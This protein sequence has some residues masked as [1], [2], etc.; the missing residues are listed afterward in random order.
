VP[1][2]WRP[3][4]HL[5][6]AVK[7]GRCSHSYADLSK[8][9]R[10]WVVAGLTRAGFTA[11]AIDGLLRCSLRTVRV[12]QADP[13]FQ[14]C[15][16]YMIETENSEAEIR[17]HQSEEARLRFEVAELSGEND[18]L[19]NRLTR[20]TEK[21]DNL[22]GKGLHAMTPY[23]TYLEPPSLR[24]RCRECHRITVAESRARRKATA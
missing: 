5:I 16:R 9:D 22:C 11:E 18:R 3:D 4:E 7:T 24:K 19:R 15:L 20:L 21:V 2:R 23:N 13:M 12:I 14:V 8:P 1:Q 10:S 6:D 17:L